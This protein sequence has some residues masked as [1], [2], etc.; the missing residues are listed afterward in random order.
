MTR[1]RSMGGWIAET[2]EMRC[3]RR[4]P[5]EGR[6]AAKG[7]KRNGRGRAARGAQ[8]CALI[9]RIRREARGP[10]AHSARTRTLA[11]NNL[12]GLT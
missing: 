9:A 5:C 10:P 2:Y 3:G 7:S 4:G 12:L 11:P 8:L 6:E 1:H